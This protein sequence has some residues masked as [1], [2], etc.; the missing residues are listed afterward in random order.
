MD[1]LTRNSRAIYK[2]S[3]SGFKTLGDLEGIKNLAGYP[4]REIAGKGIKLI[5]PNTRS[6]KQVS[7]F[8]AGQVEA[9]NM[10]SKFLSTAGVA[11]SAAGVVFETFTLIANAKDFETKKAFLGDLESKIPELEEQLPEIFKWFKEIKD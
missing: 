11:L 9:L 5:G 2:L 8:N 1:T 4:S 3:E 6:I 10:T 7:S